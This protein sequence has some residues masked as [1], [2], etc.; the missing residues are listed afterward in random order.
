MNPSKY[1]KVLVLCCKDEMLHNPADIVEYFRECF[2][3]IHLHL[4]EHI[5]CLNVSAY[6]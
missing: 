3:D 1:E 2:G 6:M 4:L 5:Q